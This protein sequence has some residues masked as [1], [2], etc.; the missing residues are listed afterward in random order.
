VFQFP[1]QQKSYT[2]EQGVHHT[3]AFPFTLKKYVKANEEQL[4]KLKYFTM[5][6]YIYIYIFFE[7]NP[8]K[9]KPKSLQHIIT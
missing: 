1:V 2:W 9:E 5:P 7:K 8:L 4:W 6:K 3:M